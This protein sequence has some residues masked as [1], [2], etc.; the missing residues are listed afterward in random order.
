MRVLV[1]AGTGE[2]RELA[3]LLASGGV[4]VVLSLAGRTSTSAP[5]PGVQT[6]VGGFGG[7]DGLAAYLAVER[8]DRVV[9]ATHPFAATISGHA[10][11]A[12]RRAAT[13]LLVL[14]R[15][16]WQAVAG[17]RWTRVPDLAAAAR[18]VLVSPPGTVLLT[19]GRGDLGAF[20]GDDVHDFVVRTIEWPQGPTPPYMT[21][22]RDR[23]PF[24]EPDE[25][26]LMRAHGVGL[27]VTK[28]S[29]GAA[30]A[31]KL[32]AARRLAVPVLVVD[33]PPLPAE[34]AVVADVDAALA[35]VR[36]AR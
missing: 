14:Q 21:L 7:A 5:L 2:A 10:A 3:G 25:I 11:E 18:E 17:D 35:W 28:D 30:T 19:T 26:A 8:I 6:R 27:L 13:P 12:C 4:D 34:T 1:L 20:A 29:G 22:L 23:G 15:P 24:D 32:T 36:G 16:G 33:R 31:A 9:D